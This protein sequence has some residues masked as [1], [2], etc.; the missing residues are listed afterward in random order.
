MFWGDIQKHWK[1]VLEKNHKDKG[2][3]NV[4]RWELYIKYKQDIIKKFFVEVLHPKVVRIVCTC[5]ED[6][7]IV[8]GGLKSNWNT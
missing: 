5:A 6:N 7:C 1:D 2:D 4:L 3:F 8:K